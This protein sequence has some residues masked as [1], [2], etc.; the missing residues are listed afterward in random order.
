MFLFWFKIEPVG[1]TKE[2]KLTDVEYFHRSF[3]A[4]AAKYKWKAFF[5]QKKTMKCLNTQVRNNDNQPKHSP[6]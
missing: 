6:S 1:L 5:S 2:T 3:S 4:P